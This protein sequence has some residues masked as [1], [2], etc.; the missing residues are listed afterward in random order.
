MAFS[1]ISRFGSKIGPKNPIAL[2]AVLM[3]LAILAMTLMDATAKSL[4]MD[5][6]PPFQVIWARYASQSVIVLLVF[7][8]QLRSLMRTRY[9]GMQLLRS[10]LLFLA[11]LAFFTSLSF[12][13]IATASAVF[14]IAPLLITV[15][16]F[17]VLRERVGPWRWLGVV[18]GLCGALIV[19]RPGSGVFSIG[20]L[21]PAVAALFYAA[22][23]I[24]TRFLGQGENP[25]TSVIYAASIGTIVASVIVPSYWV[26]VTGVAVVKMLLLGVFGTIGHSL[27]VRSL[28]L[29]DASFLAPFGYS[30]LLFSIIWGVLFFA[31]YPDIW[32]YVG[33]A[34]IV[35]AGLFVWYRE[36][37]G[38]K[39][40]AP[41]PNPT[42]RPIENYS[43]PANR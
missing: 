12:I 20:T 41:Q 23:A 43:R 14:E 31:E 18:V 11:T 5:G 10:C 22:F 15:L 37:K 36:L 29:A 19:I 16:A 4:M 6:Y 34:T 21:L 3:V 17:F 8:P 33:G 13:E 28:M 39:P 30:S 24:A 27:L 35:G 25:W 7:A 26:D 9:P 32:V 42:T 1:F 38:P 2:G 40:P